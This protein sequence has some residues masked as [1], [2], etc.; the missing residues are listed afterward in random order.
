MDPGVSLDWSDK[1]CRE[2]V[3]SLTA[4]SYLL[5]VCAGGISILTMCGNLLIIVSITYFKQLRTPTN[6]IIL[7]LAVTDL[8][9]GAFVMPFSAVLHI[10]SCWHHRNFLCLARTVLDVLLSTCSILNL[11]FISMDRY[12][13]VFQP[14][15]Y[16]RRMNLCVTAV[17][18]AV[19]WTTAS[20]TGVGVLIRSLGKGPSRQCVIDK[21]TPSAFIGPLVVFFLP[22]TVIVIV[23]MKILSV[24][25]R[26]AR[27]IQSTTTGAVVKTDHKATKTL[28]IVIGIFLMCWFPFFLCFT[29]DIYSGYRVPETIMVS[30]K[31][32]G[33]SNSMVNPFIY[34]FFYA[35]FRSA[36]RIILSRKIYRQDCSYIN[37]F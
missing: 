20:L 22:A 30:F 33:W 34:G 18:I 4:A 11:C 37:L 10:S 1:Q 9:V 5:C 35:W 17:I 25:Q 8:L 19:I 28:S 15:H 21:P 3:S 12:Q 26:Q 31:W 2:N 23:Y 32:L 36:I 7:S 16:R 24:A 14:F 13:S 6:C 27:S 29:V